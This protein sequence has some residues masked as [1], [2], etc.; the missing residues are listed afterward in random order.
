MNTVLPTGPG[1]WE[2]AANKGKKAAQAK[3]KA[4][5]TSMSS[6][7]PSSTH[8]AFVTMIES[9]LMKFLVSQNTDG[10]HRKSGVPADKM[11]ELHGNTNLE[12]CTDCGKKYLRDFRTRN[13]QSVHDHNTGRI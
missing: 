10:L 8:M 3:K 1:C 13:A 6:A 7:F 11:S 9:G 5:R 4:L 12:K 2:L